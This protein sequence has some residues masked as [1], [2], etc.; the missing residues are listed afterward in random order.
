MR[1]SAT[2]TPRERLVNCFS[3]VF[4][5]LTAEEIVVAS[6][7]SVGSWDSVASI[8]LMSVLEEEFG[9]SIEPEDIEQ[10]VSFELI[11]NYLQQEKSVS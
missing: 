4:P 5:D 8:T 1:Q 9:I 3:A 10:L 6:P 7:A 2:L 11:L